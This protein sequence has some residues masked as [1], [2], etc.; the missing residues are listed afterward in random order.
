MSLT[1]TPIRSCNNCQPLSSVPVT[2]RGGSPT[3]RRFFAAKSG[4]DWSRL[5]WYMPVAV[6]VGRIDVAGTHIQFKDATRWGYRGWIHQRDGEVLRSM[7][8]QFGTVCRQHCETAVCLWERSKFAR[9][10]T[11]LFGCGQQRTPSGAAGT[12]CD[13]GAVYKF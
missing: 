6:A 10:K 2:S 4:E 11:Y 7:G 13:R 1:P 9:L 8:R 3:D 5:L 12:F